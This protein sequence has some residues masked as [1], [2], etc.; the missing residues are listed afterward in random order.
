MTKHG[1]KVRSFCSWCVRDGRAPSAI[2]WRRTRTSS[3]YKISE[4]CTGCDRPINPGQFA[5]HSR[6]TTEELS[7]MPWTQESDPMAACQVCGAVAPLENHH[8]APR[9]QFGAEAD[10]WPQVR[11]CRA[12]HS[13]WHRAMGQEIDDADERAAAE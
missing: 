1:A 7:A 2:E 4:F 5:A 10:L 3:G 11:V 8:L 6:F 12:C 13:F 9:A